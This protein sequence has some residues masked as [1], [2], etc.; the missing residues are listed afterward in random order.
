[1]ILISHRGNLN[2]KQPS[3]ENHP[4]YILRALVAGFNVEIDIW[5]IDGKFKLGH[6][7]PQYDFPFQLF[8]NY[9]G[10]LW[11]HCK[12]VEAMVALNE[13]PNQHFLNYFFHQEDDI[14]LTSKGYIWAYP[15]KQP[16]K[17]SI[18]VMPELNKDDLTKATGICSDYIKDYK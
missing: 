15:G 13:F 7:E 10:K 8:E 14:T 1:M 5:F 4:D 12:N 17:N 2:G 6:D 3:N 11:L 18:A 9:F 16:I